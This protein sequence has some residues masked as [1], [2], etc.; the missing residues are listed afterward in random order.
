[1]VQPDAVDV[2]D[3]YA[4]LLVNREPDSF[5][6]AKRFEHIV[7]AGQ[8]VRIQIRFRMQFD[9]AAV[10]F[11][12]VQHIVDERKQKF[13][14][15]LNLPQ[16]VLQLFGIMDVFNGEFQNVGDGADRRAYV[17]QNVLT[18]YVE[19]SIIH[20]LPCRSSR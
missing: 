13:V 8:E 5:V 16:V 6:L 11:R 17:M 4:R 20:N 3:L 14:G 19:I 7:E 9:L 15:H 18:I 1:M 10:D 2:D 12:D